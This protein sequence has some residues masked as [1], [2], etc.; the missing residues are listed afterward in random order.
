VTGCGGDVVGTWTIVSSCVQATIMMSCGQ[1]ISSSA[2]LTTTGTITYNTDLT[3]MTTTAS[4]G[5]AT[6]S[7]PDACLTFQGTTLTCDQ[8][9]ASAQAMTPGAVSTACTDSGG[10]CK[11]TITVSQASSTESGTYSLSGNTITRTPT[12]KTAATSNYCVRGTEL[13]ESPAQANTSGV[14]VYSKQ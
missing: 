3:Y 4:T 11:C 10:V 1:V 2:G 6:V 8:L 7:E 5:T 14:T 12:G 9:G 13:D